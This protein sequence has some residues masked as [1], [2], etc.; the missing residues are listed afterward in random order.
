MISNLGESK[1][2]PNRGR[3]E[4]ADLASGVGAMALGAGLAL[5]AHAALAPYALQL[6]VV[7]PIVQDGGMT[8]KNRSESDEREQ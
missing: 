5:L 1:A 3:A 8:L 4:A 7:G 6:L 2:N